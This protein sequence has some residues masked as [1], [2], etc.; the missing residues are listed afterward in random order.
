[1]LAAI[2]SGLA[3]ALALTA[4]HE[5]TRHNV[6]QA[7]RMDILGKRALARG[8]R[9]MGYEPPHGQALHQAALAGDVASNTLYYSL[10]A[11]G[12]PTNAPV[13]GALLGFAAGVG[14]LVLPGPMGLGTKPS[15]KTS[16]TAAMT[17]ALY[18]AGGI[19]AGA[20]YAALAD[21]R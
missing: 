2:T 12:S 5:T 9:G 20:A 10:I 15:R 17:V 3:G 1:M 14:A 18:T 4:L 6:P 16:A 11:L 21:E 7:P 13:N 19:A 8:L